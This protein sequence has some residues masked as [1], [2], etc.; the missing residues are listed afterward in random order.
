MTPE[1][2]IAKWRKNPLK[3]RQFYQSHFDDLC[4]LLDVKRPS[5]AG[6][7]DGYCFDKHTLK[8]G[9]ASGYADVWKRGCFAWEY[10]G[11]RRHLTAAYAQVKQYAD[12]LEN[13]PLLIVSD[14]EEIRVHTNFTNAVSVTH[15]IGLADLNS[16]E[17]RRLLRWCWC[18][19]HRLRP[20]ETRATVT[21]KAAKA[22]GAVAAQLRARLGEEEGQRIAHFLNRIVFCLFAEDIDLLPDRLVSGLLEESVRD[23]GFVGRIG[24]LFRAMKDRDGFFGS[25]RVPWFNGGLFDDDDVIDLDWT[26]LRELFEA[27]KLDWSAI[28][29]SIFGTLFER[30]LDPEKRK[31]MAGLFD[32]PA[33]AAEAAAPEP[34]EGAA[35]VAPT[36]A[37]AGRKRRAG[38]V[39][40][41]GVGIHY[42]DPEKIMKIV[43]PVVLRPLR[44]EWE[45]VKARVAD[46]R[47][48][49]DAAGS[50]AARTRAE[51]EAR[52]AYFAFRERLGRYR[53]LDPAC[54]SGNFLYMA[55]MRLKDLDREV[56]REAR[57]LGLPADRERITPDAVLG[58]EVNPYAAEL[59]RTTVWIGELQ[60]QM[61]NA[62]A[63]KRAPILGR[64][65]GI[66]NRDAL[67]NPDGTEAEWP[68]A[69][70]IIGNPP[71]LGNKKQ[72]RAFTENYLQQLRNAYKRF[73]TGSVD[74]VCYWIFKAS[75]TQA[76]RPCFWGFVTTN[77]VRSGANIRAIEVALKHGV[78]FDAWPD[79]EWNIDGANVR[80]SMFSFSP[81][82]IGFAKNVNGKA[83]NSIQASLSGSNEKD[84]MDVS[85]IK[86]IEP[87]GN[88]SFQGFTK[89]GAFE[90]D[91]T[92]ARQWLCAPI[93]PNGRKNSDV[94]RPIYSG[95]DLSR[96][97]PDRW[98]IDFS[99]LQ[100]DAASYYEQP[101]EYVLK[102]VKEFR[103]KSR[104][105]NYKK[106]WWRFAEH[107][108]GLRS[109]LSGLKK[110]IVTPKVA[111]HRFFRFVDVVMAADNLVI[112]IAKEGHETFGILESRF[113]RNWAMKAAFYI[114]VGNDPT[115]TPTTCFETFPF[116]EGLTPDIP[117][118]RYADDPRAQAIAAAARELDEKREAWLNPPDLVVRVPEV[119][120]GYPD[121]ILPKDDRAAAILK[122]RT[123][124]NLYN[125][126]PAWLDGLHRRLDAAVAAAYGWPADIPDDEALARLFALNQ[127]RARAGAADR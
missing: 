13:P 31:A 25:Q 90:V 97:L 38:K 15:T 65:D 93:N 101:F 36:D 28:E 85:K 45:A 5:D 55:L 20:A 44:A 102:N 91:G 98:V 66:Q 56:E 43:E 1:E 9:G 47:A 46:R 124:T 18:E 2:F 49:R 115:Y 84:G 103:Q 26:Q 117:A 39:T 69:D 60:W 95:G 127:E 3:E 52:G 92:V 82:G 77:S 12:A 48:A 113:H 94:L 75:I 122:K 30:G 22:V 68:D 64:L 110:C 111:R 29:P 37:A 73:S 114:G 120:P 78:L 61:R 35:P 17:A 58:I 100:E 119:V 121:R 79:E 42:T 89:G 27:S 62:G 80:V 53:V 40:G 126:R 71:F 123:L 125:E 41:R 63:V 57:D 99:D 67:L 7:P 32:L 108:P 14:A 109:A 86:R 72:A 118:E 106:Y 116:P 96:R 81:K 4:R 54:G 83:V 6:D 33:T 21:D 105:E 16:V 76:A 24:G 50:D 112:I 10:K 8:L 70:A 87:S 59:A 88:L 107:R 19:P 11:D 104:R 34:P 74:L 51:E 23:G